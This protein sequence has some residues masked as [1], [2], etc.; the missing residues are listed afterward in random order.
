MDDSIT[1]K[2]NHMKCIHVVQ[3]PGS[4]SYVK[5]EQQIVVFMD[6][7]YHTYIWIGAPIQKFKIGHYYDI[8][9]F[10]DENGVLKFMRVLKDYNAETPAETESEQLDDKNK[11]PVDVFDLIFN[12]DDTHL[13]ND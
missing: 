11:S 6:D 5:Q 2:F 7:F 13:T 12:T 10:C 4:Y 1:T 8:R 3:H 9:A